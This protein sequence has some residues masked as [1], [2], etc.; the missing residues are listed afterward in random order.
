MILPS[1]TGF[2]VYTKTG[3]KFCSLVKELLEDESPLIIDTT[4]CIEEDKEVF[5]AF[6][7]SIGAINYKTFPMVF[8]D[9]KFIGGFKETFELI[10]KQ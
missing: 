6:T 8:F 10:K 4:P 3:C 5:L 7:E 1:P 9:G 2:T